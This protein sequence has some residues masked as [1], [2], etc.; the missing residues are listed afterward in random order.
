MRRVIVVDDEPI[1]RMDL[2]EMLRELEFEVVGE[3]GDGFDAVELCRRLHPDVEIGR[4]H[5]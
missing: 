3:A 1:T 2:G 5:V 4:A